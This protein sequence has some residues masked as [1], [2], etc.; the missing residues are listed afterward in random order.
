MNG[1]SKIPLLLVGGVLATLASGLTHDAR[2]QGA[3]ETQVVAG[4]TLYKSFC[5]SCHGVGGRGDGPVAPHLR[6]PPADLTQ[7]AVK[8]NGVFPA[9]RLEHIIDGRETVRTHG[10]SDMPVWGDALSRSASGGDEAAV[11]ARIRA[12]VKHLE[13]IQ[14]RRSD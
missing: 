5:A 10:K 8:N 12:I 6:R 7:F 9:E 11:Q 1:L 2:G 14:Q 4:S 13:S 3:G